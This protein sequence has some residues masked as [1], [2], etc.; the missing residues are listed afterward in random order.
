[1][2][3]PDLIILY[4][5]DVPASEAFYAGLLGKAPVESSPAFAMFVLANGQRLGLWALHTVEPAAVA[6]GGGGELC[7]ALDGDAAVDALHADWQ[8]RGL[9]FAQPPTSMEFGHTFV[10]LDPDSHRLRVY[11]PIPR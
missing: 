7:I 3:D 1:M 11:S 2:T 8:A 4:V 9:T 6:T 5:N 10:A